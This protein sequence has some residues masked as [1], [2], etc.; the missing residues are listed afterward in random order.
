[1]TTLCDAALDYAAHGWHIFPCKP[2]EKIPL[3]EHG[4]KDATT[5]VAIIKV[6]WQQWPDANIGLACGPA[7]ITA[8][9]VD[10]KNGALGMESWRDL[11]AACGAAISETV[12]A[13]TPTGGLHFLYKTNG[14][15]I[16]N[17]AGKL[18]AGLDIRADGGYIL[19][20]PSIHP[21]GGVYQ[22]AMN[23]A[24]D[25]CEMIPFPPVLWQ[26]LKPVQRPPAP[27][28]ENMIPTGQRNATL[29][30]LGG[31]MRRRN[32]SQEAIETALLTENAKRCAPP[33]PD[34]EIL[35]IAKSVSRYTAEKEMPEDEIWETD[36]GNG[37]R[38]ARQHGENVRWCEQLGGWYIWDGKR[39]ARDIDESAMSLAKIT[40]RTLRME[41]ARCS[42]DNKAERLWK[43]ARQTENN[44]RLEAMLKQSRSEKGI[45]AQPGD[46][47]QNPWVLNCENGILDLH[48]GTLLPHDR[49]AICSK[50][51]PVTFD[52]QAQAPRWLQFIS[53]ITLGDKDLAGYLQR[54]AGQA[55]TGDTAE[56][57][58]ALFYGIGHN[59]KSTYC[60]TLANILGDYA[61]RATIET[62]LAERRSS[63][64]ASGDRARL[65]GARLVIASEIPQGRNL[66]EQFVKDV[67]GHTDVLTARQLYHKE[68]NFRPAFKLIM[69]GNHKPS[70][71]G[72]DGAIWGRVHLVPFGAC[73]EGADVDLHIDETL[74]QELSGILNWAMAGCLDWQKN[75]LGVP[76]AVSQATNAYRVE[77][78]ILGQFLEDCCMILPTAKV[79]KAALK[80]AYLAW[81][82]AESMTPISQNE[83][84]RSMT[85][86]G[87]R[88]TRVGNRNARAWAGIGLKTPMDDPT[89]DNEPTPL[90]EPEPLSNNPN[91]T[92]ISNADSDKYFSSTALKE[93]LSKNALVMLEMLADGSVRTLRS[94]GMSTSL[95]DAELRAALQELQ[96]TGLVRETGYGWGR[97]GG[98]DG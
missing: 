46:F 97:T 77:E 37:C 57:N 43:W 73:F 63:S 51:A 62:F 18:G 7:G 94:L 25:E 48:T 21:N 56:R 89:P 3:T 68:F 6:W 26:R 58:F 49:A 8:I 32:M 67:T 86:R 47:D 17:S 64:A 27:A 23:A 16:G 88:E 38:F 39:W 95:P 98:G 55:L 82:N 10:C 9:D 87:Y 1:M 24:P 75:G 93:N 84:S 36:A 72:T 74:D 85:E 92:N 60:S 41:A 90:P 31:T 13:E 80:A 40:A 11:L 70:I 28:V 61:L 54:K 44:T 53:E 52:P 19:L 50:M 96:A 45:Y 30:S 65:A 29:L 59:G 20:A 15:T 66:D 71:R 2:H 91:N 78:D 79:S 5:D 22:W 83:F 33:L 34:D 69:F 42:D 35:M 76:Q 4:F 12:T 81:C 14:Y